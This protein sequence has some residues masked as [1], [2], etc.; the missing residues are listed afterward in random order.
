M[1]PPE[2]TVPPGDGPEVAL[3]RQGSE[4]EPGGEGSKG[5]RSLGE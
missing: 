1:R 5:H 2:S 3:G 4:G